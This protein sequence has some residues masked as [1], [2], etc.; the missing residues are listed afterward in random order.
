MEIKD[1]SFNQYFTKYSKVNS[2]QTIIILN[3][4]STLHSIIKSDIFNKLKKSS[5]FSF[6]N[7]YLT[8]IFYGIILDTGA[9]GVSII[10]K[11]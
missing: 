10:K 5:T 11:P 3:N 1:Y 2:T 4:Q 7:K 9:A 6:N 8:N